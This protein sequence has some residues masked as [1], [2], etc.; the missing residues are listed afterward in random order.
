MPASTDETDRPSHWRRR[1]LLGGAG[2]VLALTGWVLGKRAYRALSMSLLGA[3][4]TREQC[5]QLLQRWIAHKSRQDDPLVD[6]EDVAFAEQVARE[7]PAFL[8]DVSQ[9]EAQLTTDEAA[10]G[11]GA[12]NAD[13]LERCVQ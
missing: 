9:C 13:A 1:E 6:E 8:A 7:R 10:C 5:E 4:A 11:I 3:A 2:V 12:P